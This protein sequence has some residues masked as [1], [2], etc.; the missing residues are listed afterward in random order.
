MQGLLV[1]QPP[2][3]TLLTT[4]AH[5]VLKHRVE[6]KPIAHAELT[7]LRAAVTDARQR[8]NLRIQQLLLVQQHGS[9][10]SQPAL[11]IG[12]TGLAMAD[13]EL[14]TQGHPFIP[15]RTTMQPEHL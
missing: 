4:P 14:E 8:A 11:Q 2:P 13:M 6:Y 12:T 3:P 1:A 5:P 15:M 7:L 9:I 10:G